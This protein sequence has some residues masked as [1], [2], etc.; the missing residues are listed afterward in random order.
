MPGRADTTCARICSRPEARLQRSTTCAWCWLAT[1]TAMCD[2]LSF[3]PSLLLI[4]CAKPVR[5]PAISP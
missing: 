2:S 3:S 5:L 1:A 4:L